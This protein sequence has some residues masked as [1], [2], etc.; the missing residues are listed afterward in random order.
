MTM[1]IKEHWTVGIEISGVGV[2]QS[3]SSD[4]LRGAN[5][6]M[7]NSVLLVT[8]GPETGTLYFWD[9]GAHPDD[10]FT[11]LAPDLEGFLATFFD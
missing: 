2:A 11:E 6:G 1:R 7:A 8:D 3:L 4:T 5:D 10:M 9:H